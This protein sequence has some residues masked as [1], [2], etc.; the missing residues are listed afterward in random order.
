MPLY[1]ID[2]THPECSD[3]RKDK[4]GWLKDLNRDG[5]FDSYDFMGLEPGP[6]EISEDDDKE[7]FIEFR[8][9]LR[10]RIQRQ[11]IVIREKSR[12]LCSGDPPSW[13]YAGGTVTS[14]VKGLE[15]IVLNN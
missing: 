4:I 15:D 10:D 8:V 12:F 3:F 1:I 5:M 14:E 7:G 9:R 6:Q 11:D 13:L 2:T